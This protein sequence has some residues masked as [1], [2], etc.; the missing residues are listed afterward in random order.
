MYGPHF[1]TDSND[2]KKIFFE[3]LKQSSNHLRGFFVFHNIPYS[4]HYLMLYGMIITS[5][6]IRNYFIQICLILTII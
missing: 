5:K 1:M 6:T 3:K 4:Q 2:A